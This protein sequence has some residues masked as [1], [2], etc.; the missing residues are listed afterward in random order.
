MVSGY[1]GGGDEAHAAYG[2]TGVP[3]IVTISPLDTTYTETH[4]GFY[5]VLSAFQGFNK[6]MFVL[7]Q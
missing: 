2:I 1:D 6:K 5:G 4:T 3:S 7:L